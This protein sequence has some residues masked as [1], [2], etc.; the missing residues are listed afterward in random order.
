M[1][2]IALS[3]T[4]ITALKKSLHDYYPDFKS[5]HLSEAIAFAL[6][7]NTYASLLTDI[8]N[9]ANDPPIE[10][11]DDV[12]FFKRLQ[13]FGHGDDEVFT[14]EIFQSEVISTVPDSAYDIKYTSLRDKAWRNLLVLTINEGIKQKLFSLRPDDNRWVG[15]TGHESTYRGDGV[16]FKFT[17]PNGLL[18]KGYVNDAG[19]GELA[20]HSAVNPKSDNLIS[21]NSG[22]EAGDAFAYC[23]LERQLGAWMQSSKSFNCKNAILRDLANMSVIP[24]G[25]GDKGRI[26]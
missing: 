3:K 5:S 1:A 9:Y 4:S 26:M 11:L 16:I 20:I 24:L 23:W 10:L 17:L 19:H 2:S 21:Y 22:L 15:A 12:R 13:E 6:N 7:R 14:F 25:Y 8:K 18:A